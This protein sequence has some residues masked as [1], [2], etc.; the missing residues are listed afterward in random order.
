MS[1]EKRQKR[2]ITGSELQRRLQES[3]KS[4]KPRDVQ[5]LNQK[6]FE[7]LK[8]AVDNYDVLDA[9]AKQQIDGAMNGFQKDLGPVLEKLPDSKDKRVLKRLHRG[10]LGKRVMVDLL[11]KE[12]E[13]MPAPEDDNSAKS[14]MLLIEELQKVTDFFC[15]ICDNTLRGPAAFGQLTLL[16]I[17]VSEL[18]VALHLGHHYYTNQAYSHVRTVIECVDKIELFRREPK[19]AEIWC[20]GDARAIWKE[21]SPKSV[22]IKLGRPKYDPVYGF[23]SALGPHGSFQAV[24]ARTYRSL[25]KSSKGNLQIHQWLGGCPAEHHIIFVNGG[26]FYAVYLV[27]L[28]LVK[29]FWRFLNAAEVK[30]ALD[31]NA[32]KTADYL[33]RYFLPWAKDNGLDVTQLEE[34]LDSAQWGKPE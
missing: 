33:R 11:L 6:L 8:F 21:L 5:A 7:H 13:S 3:L 30:E 26:M 28:Q 22:R 17:C 29:S 12:L 16:G 24:Q 32:C 27:L 4:V 25:Q 23:F 2:S 31:R 20:S 19:W 18:V 10:M 9:D 34:R 1:D 14:R 15:D